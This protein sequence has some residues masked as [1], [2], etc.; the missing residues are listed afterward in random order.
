IF[1]SRLPGAQ[2]ISGFGLNRD[3]TGGANLLPIVH[4]YDLDMLE[5]SAD[6]NNVKAYVLCFDT[7]TPQSASFAR[8]VTAAN[9]ADAAVIQDMSILESAAGTSQ[10]D[11]VVQGI[12]G[13]KP[14]AFFYNR[15]TLRYISDK[16]GET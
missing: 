7:G 6:F 15:T 9:R 10:N 5:T 12:V 1:F 8:T 2:N 3:G 4:P 11:L 16:A 14:R 13:G